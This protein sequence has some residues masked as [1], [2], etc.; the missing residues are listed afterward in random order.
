[1]GESQLEMA[2]SDLEGIPD[3]VLPAGCTIRAYRSGDEWAWCRLVNEGI[4]G[5]YTPEKLRAEMAGAADF[6]PLDLLFVVR[7]EEVVGTAWALRQAGSPSGKG[8]V[9]MVAVAL[10]HRGGGLGRALVVA[11]LHRLREV[12]ARSAGL[13]TDDFRPAAIRIY[14]GVGFRPVLSHENHPGRWRAVYQ[15]LGIEEEIE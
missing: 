10:E 5:E 9:H 15:E 14:L 12:G 4:G 3:V 11:V 2:R 6:D 13:K 8:I 1:M 7:G